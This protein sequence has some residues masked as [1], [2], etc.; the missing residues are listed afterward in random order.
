[1]KLLAVEAAKL[2]GLPPETVMVR[3]GDGKVEVFIGEVKAAAFVEKERVS[4]SKVKKWADGL[5]V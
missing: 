2:L 1:M 4:E 3:V 5:K